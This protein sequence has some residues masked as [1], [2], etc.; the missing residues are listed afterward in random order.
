[1]A[2]TEIDQ[3]RRARD[4]RATRNG[5]S[6]DDTPTERGR[7]ADSH[8]PD[9]ASDVAPRDAHT[10]A[11]RQPPRPADPEARKQQVLTH[12]TASKVPG[13]ADAV[14]VKDE[15]VFFVCQPDGQVPIGPPHGLGLYYHD[16]RFLSGYELRLSGTKPSELAATAE[17]GFRAIV[18]ATNVEIRDG[19][20]QTIRKDDL[21]VNWSRIVDGRDLRLTDTIQ[22][23]NYGRT[24]VHFTAEVSFSSSFE[25]IFTIRGLLEEQHG[26]LHEPR[27]N[28]D[29]HV[30][31]E[32]DGGDDIRREVEIGFSR[33]PREH[34]KASATF[35]F[36]LDEAEQVELIVGVLLSESSTSGKAPHWKRLDPE[37]L[38]K[39]LEGSVAEWHERTVSVESSLLLDSVLR[40]AMRDLRILRATVGG[41]RYLAAGVP[42]FV[43]LFGRDSLIA[44]LQT[45]AFNPDIAAETLRLLASMQG[46]KVDDWRDEAPGKIL[47][48][49]R[50]GEYAHLHEIPHTP[51][52][53]SVDSTPLFLVLIARHAAW[54]GSLDLFRELRHNV[55]RALQWI[56]RYGDSDGDGFLDYTSG[57]AH[58]L[59]N[60]G[61]KDSGDAIVNAD[62][63][64]AE[65]PIALVEVQGYVY[66]AKTELAALYRR[67]G[68]AKTADRLEREAADLRR[69][70]NHDFWNDDLDGYVLALQKGGRQA[71]VASSNPGQALWT[72]IVDEERAPRVAEQLMSDE[73]FSGWGVRTLSSKARRY[74]PIGY[75]LGTVWPHDNGIIAAGLRRYGFDTEAARIFT[76]LVQAA[77]AFDEYRLPECF[78]GFSRDQYGVPVRYPVAC[79]PQAWAAGSIPFMLQVMLGLVPE[80]FDRRLRV[81]RPMLPDFAT[82][83]TLKGLAVAEA[84]VDLRFERTE[85]G[86]AVEVLGLDGQLEVV[87]EPPIPAP[88]RTDRQR[89]HAVRNVAGDGN[90][91]ARTE[92]GGQRS[93]SGGRMP[94]GT[95]R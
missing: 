71:A 90:R 74:N 72:G 8:P 25:D 93:P 9:D 73:M 44:G 27:W 41:Q 91:R 65:P 66:L 23:H 57:V 34:G 5:G 63:S 21:G 55:D 82:E 92:P 70:F 24:P 94:S 7:S 53:G 3:E 87:I 48:E 39:R 36:E 59:V 47:H 51:Y 17:R 15:D 64:L 49:L 56:D 68:D 86:V 20:G 54:T 30:V 76:S 50:V 14:V 67:D 77:L 85:T 10:A 79:H 88:P 26:S 28:R 38:E 19:T 89:A 83:L 11:S 95:S 58:G 22:F 37:A 42:W 43:A 84:R 78:T 12:H 81:V 13:I 16:C 75:H 62:G 2:K 29:G 32:Y 1:M 80:A 60:Q 52:Y 31:F 61:W 33:K 35:E 46:T 6:R 40:R 18:E 69:R 45:L 4:G